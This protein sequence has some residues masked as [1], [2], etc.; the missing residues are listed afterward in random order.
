MIAARYD[1]A[2]H[3]SK[4]S[5]ITFIYYSH[6]SVNELMVHSVFLY[7]DCRIRLVWHANR[8]LS[9]SVSD[10]TIILLLTSQTGYG[11]GP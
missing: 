10:K 4:C 11:N 1:I 5:I 7:S 2:R 3:P 6:R 8:I 9:K